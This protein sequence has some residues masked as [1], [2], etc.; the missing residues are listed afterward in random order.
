MAKEPGSDRDAVMPETE[1]HRLVGLEMLFAKD[2]EAN[3]MS[4]DLNEPVK[5][6]TGETDDEALTQ[7]V[8]VKFGEG[9]EMRKVV[10]GGRLLHGAQGMPLKKAITKIVMAVNA[11]LK[12]GGRD[13]NPRRP[14]WEAGILPLNYPR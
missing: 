13:S 4:E 2:A 1:D 3:G 10:R 9:V 6:E 5:E 12:S 7:R 8:L 11:K 14:A